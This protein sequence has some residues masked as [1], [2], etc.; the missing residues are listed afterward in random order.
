MKKIGILLISLIAIAICSH[1]QEGQ[2]PYEAKM[3]DLGEIQMQYFDYGGE[4]PTLIILQDFHN[5]YSGPMAYPPNHP[6]IGFYKSL[7]A[8]FRVLAPIKRGYGGSTDSHWGF[9][10]ATMSEDLIDFMNALDIEKAFLYGRV[11]ANQELTWLAQYYPERIEGLLY[12]GNPIITVG[13]M[14]EEVLEFADHIQ[15]FAMDGFD[16]DKARQVY[17]S[18]SMWRPRFLKDPSYR[19]EVPAMRFSVPGQDG[20]SFNLAFGTRE[21]LEQTLAMPIEDREEAKQYVSALLQDSLQHEALYQKLKN[22]N[23]SNDVEE[24]MKRAFGENLITLEEPEEFNAQTMEAYI[25]VLDWQRKHIFEFK[26][27]V[28]K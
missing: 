24:G 18:R 26:Q 12:D 23:R 1:G 13:C 22:C 7:T 20:M 9:D 8:E 25:G 14:D 2:L 15:T 11:P 17:L 6:L 4:G 16:R 19:I 28:M 21:S 27:K 10:V 3:A 5:Y